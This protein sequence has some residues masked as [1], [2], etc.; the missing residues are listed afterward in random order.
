MIRTPENQHWVLLGTAPASEEIWGLSQIDFPCG[1]HIPPG[2]FAPSG[3]PLERPKPNGEVWAMGGFAMELAQGGKVIRAED[4]SG[5]VAGC[6]PWVCVFHDA[7]LD[8]LRDRTHTIEMWD[9]G[10]SIFYGLWREATHRLGDL[11]PSADFA[12]MVD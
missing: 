6:R 3:K 11:I 5:H 9:R 4:A 7:L 2:A 1:Y 12:A 8:E 10:V